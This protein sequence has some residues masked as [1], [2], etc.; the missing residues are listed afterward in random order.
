VATSHQVAP[1]E[2]VGFRSAAAGRE[3]A[4]LLDSIEL[5]PLAGV[6]LA[7]RP[8]LVVGTWDGD[9]GGRQKGHSDEL[10]FW[11]DY[12]ARIHP[13]DPKFANATG[14]R[15]TNPASLG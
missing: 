4:A 9:H 8:R 14:P 7:A 11:E 10:P 12:L 5:A 3:L 6:V 13:N 2:Y 15:L 1:E